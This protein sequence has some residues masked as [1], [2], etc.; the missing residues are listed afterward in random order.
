MVKTTVK[1]EGMRCGMCE[2]HIN[3]TVRKEFPE[4]KKVSS[5]HSKG[6][7]VIVSPE[8]IDLA[9]LKAAIDA[10]GYEYVSAASEPFEKHG[11]FGRR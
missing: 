3:D 7:T 1:V 9:R 2:A 11:L 6:E 8:P 5:S 4:V 10:T